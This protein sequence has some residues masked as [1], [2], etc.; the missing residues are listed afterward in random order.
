MQYNNKKSIDIC[1]LSEL[2][3]LTL[4]DDEAELLSAELKKMADYIYTHTRCEDISLPDASVGTLASLRDDT[5][6]DCTVIKE[7]LSA[8]PDTEGGYIRVPRVV[9]KRGD[10][11][12]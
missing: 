1:R 5:P 8:A 6:E 12:E 7:I 2:C 3:R 9:G 10:E 4:S 11:N